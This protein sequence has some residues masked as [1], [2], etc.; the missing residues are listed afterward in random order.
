MKLQEIKT[1]E[2]KGISVA[3]KVDYQRG[4]ASLVEIYSTY[5]D[6]YPN[7][8]F[9]FADRGL[10]Y[11]NGWLNILGAMQVAVTECKKLLEADLAEKSRLKEDAIV[12]VLLADGKRK[13]K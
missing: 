6:N 5:P 3:I 9:V 11:M 8:Q 13:K 4:T 1:I 2:H 7:K 10:E 12:E